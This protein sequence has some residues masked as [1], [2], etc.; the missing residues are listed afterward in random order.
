LALKI[1]GEL[2]EKQEREGAK[3]LFFG[4]T[5]LEKT[6]AMRGDEALVQKQDAIGQVL[7][8]SESAKVSIQPACELP[9]IRGICKGRGTMC[10]IGRRK[11]GLV[12][13]ASSSKG[14]V[15]V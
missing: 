3:V 12:V 15:Q 11:R 13:L 1:T 6:C 2:L 7:K 9:L 8:K 5:L 14:V 10:A 4:E